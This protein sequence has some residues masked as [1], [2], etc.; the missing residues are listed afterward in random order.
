MPRLLPTAVTLT[1][2]LMAPV[3]AHAAF[4]TQVSPAFA[5]GDP[6]FAFT[7]RRGVV[8]GPTLISFPDPFGATAITFGKSLA[9]LSAGSV[10]TGGGNYDL[11]TGTPTNPLAVVPGDSGTNLYIDTAVA[12]QLLRPPG[13][14]TPVG[15]GFISGIGPDGFPMNS[16]LGEGSIAAVLATPVS[17]FGFDVVGADGGSAVVTAYRSD[18]TS[19]GSVSLS[20]LV[21]GAFSF[22]TDDN[23]AAIRGFLITNTD[24]GGIGIDHIRLSGAAV[25]EPRSVALLGVGLAAAFGVMRRKR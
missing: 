3:A 6:D 13:S 5:P 19:L 14:N 15:E 23:S 21:D 7:T 11:P 24:P 4:L 8:F 2:A 10:T 9:G 12:G 25:P 22:R 18:G 20:G 17:T 16:A 1:L